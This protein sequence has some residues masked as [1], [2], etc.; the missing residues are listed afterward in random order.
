MSKDLGVNG[1]RAGQSYRDRDM[2]DRFAALIKHHGFA[3][4]QFRQVSRDIREKLAKTP[5]YLSKSEW[6]VLSSV[7]PSLGNEKARLALTVLIQGGV[8]AYYDV[9]TGRDREALKA[10]K[11]TFLNKHEKLLE[12]M[13]GDFFDLDGQPR[14]QETSVKPFPG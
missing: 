6:D 13:L 5:G 1:Y 11:N 2:L 9:Y 14:K 10:Q 3:A 8:D 4:S 7:Y 12:E